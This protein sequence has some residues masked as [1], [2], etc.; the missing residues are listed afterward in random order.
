MSKLAIFG[1]ILL[2]I[3]LAYIGRLVYLVQTTNA[4]VG[5]GTGS[6]LVACEES[7]PCCVSSLNPV[8]DFHIAPLQ[9]K[10]G[11]GMNDLR[12]A[13]LTEPRVV[14]AFENATRLDVTF[15]TALFGFNDDASFAIDPS[16]GKVDMRSRSRVGYSDLGVNRKRL[17]RVRSALNAP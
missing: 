4:A 10:A 8:G 7:R 3:V 16:T 13:V 12:K 9:L 15:K 14:I 1:C 17:E 2:G 6:A 11:A 5:F